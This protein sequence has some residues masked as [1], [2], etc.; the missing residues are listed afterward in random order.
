VQENDLLDM[1]CSTVTT[2]IRDAL[3]QHSAWWDH[4]VYQDP[5]WQGEAYQTWHHRNA[6]SAGYLQ[7]IPQ[8][9]CE[10]R[11]WED[12]TPFTHRLELPP[13]PDFHH[14][15]LAFD[16]KPLLYRSPAELT[17]P[18]PPALMLPSM[19][20]LFPIVQTPLSLQPPAPPFMMGAQ[21]HAADST[22]L[23]SHMVVRQIAPAPAIDYFKVF[24]SPPPSA[25][26]RSAA[27]VTATE[28]V[29]ATRRN[30]ALSVENDT[31]CSLYYTGKKR[32]IEESVAAVFKHGNGS[33]P[34]DLVMAD[35]PSLGISRGLGVTRYR[36]PTLAI[37]TT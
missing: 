8:K 5:A 9:H 1:V 25:L 6:Q 15:G 21:P 24:S 36:Q 31:A 14:E 7:A 19:L 29:A 27:A 32:K 17:L 12:G 30:E 34:E 20:F 4:I 37:F 2:V 16:V 10:V 23:G 28:A 35:W 13:L 26:P 33:R 18:L 22:F 3:V 11:E